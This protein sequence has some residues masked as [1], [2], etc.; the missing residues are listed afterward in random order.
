MSMYMRPSIAPTPLNTISGPQITEKRSDALLFIV[1][2]VTVICITPLM[3]LGGANIGFSFILGGLAALTTAALIVWRPVLGFYVVTGCVVLVEQ[4]SLP[5]PILTDNLYIFYWPPR[6]TG[7]IERPIG[8]LLIFILSTYVYHRLV[9]RLQP[10]Q[11]GALLLPFL[12]FLL[13]VSWGV[14]HGL[15]TGGDFKIIVLEVRPF[16]YLFVSYF[17]AYNLVSHKNHIRALF[18]IV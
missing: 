18:W 6:F 1:I 3:I 17:L 7:L 13:C 15:T 16:W 10:L 5:T 8:F 2:F 4:S 9:R 14:I 12:F 11:G